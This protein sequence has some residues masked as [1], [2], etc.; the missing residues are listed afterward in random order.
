MRVQIPVN[1]PQTSVRR[2]S[3]HQ[4]QGFH[5]L[6]TAP[7]VDLRHSILSNRA[8]GSINDT[9]RGEGTGVLLLSLALDHSPE[10]A[11]AVKWC[12]F[13]HVGS[14]PKQVDEFI[15]IPIVMKGGYP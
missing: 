13:R 1:H 6:S 9:L 7:L 5:H 11:P 10:A 3:L 4:F 12:G 14:D 8:P 15:A 2:I